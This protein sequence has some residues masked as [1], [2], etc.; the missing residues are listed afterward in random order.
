MAPEDGPSSV[1][2]LG[3]VIDG[4]AATP[5]TNGAVMIRGDTIVA[6]GPRADVEIPA[7][8][9]VYDLP[10]T[11]ILP[12]FVNAHVHNS[13]DVSTLQLWATS[14]VTTTRSGPWRTPD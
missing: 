6:V 10:G 8:A 1:V 13:Y 12:G 11:T 3:T 4:T 9:R 7:E 5:I 14:G 2:V